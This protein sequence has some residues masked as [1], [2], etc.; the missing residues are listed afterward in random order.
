M[1]QR[2]IYPGV[3][4]AMTKREAL[5]LSRIVEQ[6]PGVGSVTIAGYPGVRRDVPFYVVRAVDTRSGYP[7]TVNG[8]DDWYELP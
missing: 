5:R 7:F 2:Y 1:K 3:P 4:A 6:A 8:P